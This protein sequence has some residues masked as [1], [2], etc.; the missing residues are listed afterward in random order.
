MVVN[1]FLGHICI[2]FIQNSVGLKQASPIISVSQNKTDGI[3]ACRLGR[4]ITKASEL[5]KCWG[6]GF[7]RRPEVVVEY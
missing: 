6:I 2:I 4:P 3:P 5:V 1:L 7:R